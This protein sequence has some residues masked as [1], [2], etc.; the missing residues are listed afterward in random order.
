MILLSVHGSRVDLVRRFR[1]R[2]PDRR[3]LIPGAKET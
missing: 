1:R 2:L 3:V